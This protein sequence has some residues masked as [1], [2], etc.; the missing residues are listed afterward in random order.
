MYVLACNVVDNYFRYDT[1][2]TFDDIPVT[3]TPNSQPKSFQVLFK[4]FESQPSDIVKSNTIC[5]PVTR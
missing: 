1:E 3:S 4:T 2:A 5:S